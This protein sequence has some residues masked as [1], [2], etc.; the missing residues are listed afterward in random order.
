MA[1]NHSLFKI[2]SLTSG[3]K[4]DFYELCG[5]RVPAFQELYRGVAH[6]LEIP[7]RGRKKVIG[8]IDGFFLFLHWLRSANPIDKIAIAFNVGTAT[9]Y[10]HIHKVAITVRQPF[11]EMFIISRWAGRLASGQ[12]CPECGL[13]VDATVQKRGR[14]VGAFQEAKKYFSGKH[15]I[16]CLKSQVVTNREGLA[17]HVVAGEPGATHDL[18]LFR[19]HEEDLALLVRSRCGAREPT[20][21]L[22]DKGYIGFQGETLQ[23]VTPHKQPRQGNLTKEQRNHNTHVAKS[24]VV[25]ENFFGRLSVKFHIMVRRWGLDDDFYPVVFEICCA[26]VNFDILAGYGGPLR[27]E[28]GE[29]YGLI[30]T[31]ECEKGKLEAAKAAE[32]VRRRRAKRLAIREEQ[33]RL[34]RVEGQL[35]EED[36]IR[37]RVAFGDPQ[38]DEEED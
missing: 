16:Y 17:M 34:D 35:V 9:L 29:Q 14:P 36:E 25:V 5:F 26:L 4:D 11:V 18:T 22:A 30:L 10:K 38:S 33:A 19:K 13:V 6:L 12:L 1:T 15:W 24:R 2:L 8:P 27:G 37:A 20:R 31:H 32:R 3:K 23:L 7:N 28:D 21:I